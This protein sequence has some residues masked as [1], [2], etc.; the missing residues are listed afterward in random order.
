MSRV[1]FYVLDEPSP[2]GSKRVACRIAEKAWLKG[3]RVY[4]A[5]ASD[6]MTRQMDN[7]LWTYR[8]DSFTPHGIFLQHAQQD[9]PILVGHTDEPPDAEILVNLTDGVPPFH[10]RFA[11]V[12][13]IVAGDAESR[14][15][16]RERFR[17]YRDTGYDL[18]SHKL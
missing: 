14:R 11:R 15:M 8:Q 17:Y 12:S 4:I 9:L 7:L 18:H 13:E 1:D 3:H 10:G 2:E 16:G 5:T 6:S